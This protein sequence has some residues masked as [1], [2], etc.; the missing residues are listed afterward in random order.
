M[1]PAVLISS[2]DKSR[3]G[4]AR[5]KPPAGQSTPEIDGR[6]LMLCS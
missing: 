5:P 6:R 3:L 1:T 4:L 2:L